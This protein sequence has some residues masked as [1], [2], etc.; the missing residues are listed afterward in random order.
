MLFDG[1][2]ESRPVPDAPPTT[3]PARCSSR[4]CPSPTPRCSGSWTRCRRTTSSSTAALTSPRWTRTSSTPPTGASCSAR[5]TASAPPWA[6]GGAAPRWTRSSAGWR[7]PRSSAC[8]SPPPVAGAATPAPSCARSSARPGSAGSSSSRSRPGR[9]RPRRSPSTRPNGYGPCARFGH[10]ARLRPGPP[11]RQGPAR[12]LSPA[13]SA[14]ELDGGDEVGPGRRRGGR[15]ARGACRGHRRRATTS[16]VLGSRTGLA[17]HTCDVARRRPWRP[18]ARP[19]C[20]RTV[21]IPCAIA[22]GKPIA[23]AVRACRWIGFTSP[24]TAAYARPAPS[25]TR[26]TPAGGPS[27]SEGAGAP[28][29][30][31]GVAPAAAQVGAAALPDP[32]ALDVDLGDEVDQPALGVAPQVRGV[33][34]SRRGRSSAVRRRCTVMRFSRCTSP[35]SGSGNDRSAISATWRGNPRTCG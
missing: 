19:A 30:R 15:A 2:M 6:A 33:R 12:L 29:R 27:G 35:G 28:V 1:G 17:N 8:T 16:T 5:S 21:H 20:G 22:R 14:G 4:R 11:P 3:A 31:V 23:R 32:L 25:G 13:G 18:R 7:S 26:R 10:Y 9:C 24:D 34:P